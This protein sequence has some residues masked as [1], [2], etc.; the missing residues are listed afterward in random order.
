MQSAM[1]Q[2]AAHPVQIRC[3]PF[4]SVAPASFRRTS[5]TSTSATCSLS[6]PTKPLR[7]TKREV[8]PLRSSRT[9][10]RAGRQR[11]AAIRAEISYVMIKP[12]GVQRALV[13]E[14]SRISDYGWLSWEPHRNKSMQ[15]VHSKRRVVPTRDL[16]CTTLTWAFQPTN[17]G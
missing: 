17:Y 11:V 5:A 4:A 13:G 6:A 8:A 1:Q 3:R 15:Y 7:L 9:A 2:C 12:D 16:S 10:G 14:V